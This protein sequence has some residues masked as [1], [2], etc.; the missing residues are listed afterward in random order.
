LRIRQSHT[1][2]STVILMASVLAMGSSEPVRPTLEQW[3][4]DNACGVNC[5]YVLLRTRDIEVQYGRL[6]ESLLNGD[7]QTSLLDLKLAASRAGLPCHIRQASPAQLQQLGGPVICH[8][9]NPMSGRGHF[10]LVL[11]SG[12]D[13][14]L[15]MDG[16]SCLLRRVDWTTFRKNWTGYVITPGPEDGRF[17]S[18]VMMFLCGSG[19]AGIGLLS[20]SLIQFRTA[21]ASRALSPGHASDS[22]T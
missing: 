17:D 3:R 16:T 19:L 2:H 18:R 10:V 7:R 21:L 13:G 11:K 15:T 1:V 8:W 12:D 14:L 6:M 9:E 20:R 22:L 4:N 5:L